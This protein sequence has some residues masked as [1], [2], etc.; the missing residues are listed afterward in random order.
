MK[1]VGGCAKRNARR[2]AVASLENDPH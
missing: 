1:K 2:H